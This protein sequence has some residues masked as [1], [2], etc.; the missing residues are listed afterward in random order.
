MLYVLGLT[1]GS[2]PSRPSAFF[3]G[4]ASDGL[5]DAFC[6]SVHDVRVYN[7]ELSGAE[8]RLVWAEMDHARQVRP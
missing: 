3:I 1:T 2:I 5:L 6:G 8:L 7:R 4:A